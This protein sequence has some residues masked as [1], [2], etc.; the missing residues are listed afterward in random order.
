MPDKR[1]QLIKSK[2]VLDEM[3]DDSTDIV[4]ENAIKRYAKRPRAV[5]NLC[6]ADY[7][8]QLDIVYPEDEFSEEKDDEV[9]DDDHIEQ[10]VQEFDE[11]HTL[12]TLKNGIKI[13]RRK[14]NKILRYVRFS[15]RSDEENHFREKLLLFLPWRNESTD[16]IGTYESYKYHY[17]AVRRM[18]D[19]KC[20]EY[21]HHAEELELA[22]ERADNDYQDAFDELAPGTEQ[23]ESETAE[24][25]TVESEKFVYFNPDRAVATMI[26]EW[27]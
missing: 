20:K 22:R 8:A 26:L 27:K 9:N 16:L 17:T 23:I 14:N 12:L 10:V 6:L 5:E 25:Q 15:A 7:V 21:E 19:H 18:V 24:E 11:S 2:S 1:I 4:A 13:K 3:P